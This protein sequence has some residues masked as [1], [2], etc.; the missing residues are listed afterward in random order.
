MLNYH[1]QML[2]AIDVGLA[3]A[4]SDRGWFWLRSQLALCCARLVWQGL[5]TSILS[6]EDSQYTATCPRVV[7][8]G[9]GAGVVYFLSSGGVPGTSRSPASAAFSYP[10][11]GRESPRRASGKPWR[12]DGPAATEMRGWRNT[13]EIVLFEIS[14]SMK[15]FR[16]L[17]THITVS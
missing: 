1:N 4:R 10:L 6:P 16:L 7:C 11:R 17:F 12:V 8:Q 5:L 14:N 13:V 2:E 15:P 3:R 9:R